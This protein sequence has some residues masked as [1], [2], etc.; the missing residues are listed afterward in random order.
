MR[1]DSYPMPN[2]SSLAPKKR[3][4]Q[5]YISIPKTFPIWQ[6]CAQRSGF[7]QIVVF[8]LPE[9]GNFSNIISIYCSLES[10]ASWLFAALVLFLEDQFFQFWRTSDLP[11][12]SLG[13]IIKWLGR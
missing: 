5:L 11:G 13:E 10:Y 9:L 6:P 3:I 4:P 12:N 7:S 8:V 1:L 2:G